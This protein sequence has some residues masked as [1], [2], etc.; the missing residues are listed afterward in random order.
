MAAKRGEDAV[1]CFADPVPHNMPLLFLRTT[2]PPVF[3]QTKNSSAI[4]L[5]TQIPQ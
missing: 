3:G 4:K 1:G 5:G 2:D